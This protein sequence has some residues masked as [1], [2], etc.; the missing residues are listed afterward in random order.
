MEISGSRVLVLGGAGLVGL[1]I[2]RRFLENHQ[3]DTLI[4]SALTK[5]E[6]EEAKKNLSEEYKDLKIETSYGNIFVRKEFKDLRPSDIYSQKENREQFIK[7]ML[8]PLDDTLEKSFYLYD[9]IGEFKPT[10]IIDCV[11]TATA[12]AYQD[13]FEKG[14]SLFSKLGQPNSNNLTEE[15]ETLIGLQYTPQ[16]I[17]HIQILWKSLVDFNVKQYLK[18]GTTGTGG[19]GLNIPYTHS[20]D[21]PSRTLLAKSAMA[22]AH[23]MLLFLLGRT[24]LEPKNN[25]NAWKIDRNKKSAPPIIKEIKPAAAVAWKNIKMGEVKHKGKLISLFDHDPDQAVSFVQSLDEKN[26]VWSQL[27]DKGT[28]R[29]LTAPFIDSGENGIFSRGEFEAITEEGQ[30]E[31]VTPEDIAEVVEREILGGNSGSDIIGALDSAV[32][33]PSYRAGY[34]RDRAIEKLKELENESEIPSIAFE[35][36][37]PPRL[38]KLLYEA[39]L[40]TSEINFLENI[41]LS[42]AELSQ[43]MAMKIKNDQRI[44]SFILSIGLAIILPDETILRGPHL[45]IP[46]KWDIP[47]DRELNSEDLDKYSSQGWVDLR[48]KNMHVWISRFVCIQD[49][50]KKGKVDNSSQFIRNNN[51]WHNINSQKSLGSIVSW[52]FL[53]EENGERVKR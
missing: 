6:V 11:N 16:L 17:R 22:G 15:I 39:H 12:L 40:I 37:G 20:E 4:I 53:K 31:F 18:I 26:K 35:N 43:K 48:E 13:V 14:R 34:L 5:N 38:S 32:L 27:M 21:R 7:D 36:L 28:Q 1:A 46:S 19:M 30:M 42:A 23:S 51:F 3:I 10:I 33:G 25:T 52:I 8:F 49:E 2:I 44:R 45:V 50:I 47:T 41:E 29:V 9:L 24:A